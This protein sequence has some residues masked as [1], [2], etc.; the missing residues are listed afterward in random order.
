MQLLKP[1]VARDD[2]QPLGRVLRVIETDTNANGQISSED[3][4]RLVSV[5][6]DW[7]QIYDIASNISKLD[8]VSVTGTGTQV[9]VM[10]DGKDGLR[11]VRFSLETGEVAATHPIPAL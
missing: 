1:Q 7:S 9:D 4:G 3:A 11:L 5:S 10:V 6:S 8:F 2:D